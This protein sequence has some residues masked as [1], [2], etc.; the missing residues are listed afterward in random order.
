[1]SY[2]LFGCCLFFMVF[3]VVG[4]VIGYWCEVFLVEYLVGGGK[5]FFV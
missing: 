5:L 1:M 2:F 3:V 4:D